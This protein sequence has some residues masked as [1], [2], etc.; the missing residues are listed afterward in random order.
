M[1]LIDDG[2]FKSAKEFGDYIIQR[3]KSVNR[4]T[5]DYLGAKAYYFISVA[6]EKMNL[7]PSLRPYMFEAYKSSCLHLDQIGQ[8]TTMN[9][10]VRSYLQQNLYE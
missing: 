8:A 2:D 10:I 4:R 5:L 3:M 9:I 7:L 1:K 6:Y